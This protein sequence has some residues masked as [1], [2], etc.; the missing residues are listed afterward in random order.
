MNPLILKLEN[1]DELSDADRRT[2]Q[3]VTANSRAVEVKLDLIAEGDVPDD[4]R[5]ILDGFACRVA[6]R[7]PPMRDDAP[8]R[9]W[10]RR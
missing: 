3:A 7:A 8:R 10:Y 1:L 2:L 9:R 4:V 5:L 6:H